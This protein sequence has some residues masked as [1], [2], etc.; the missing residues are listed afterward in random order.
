MRSFCF[1][2]WRKAEDEDLD[3]ELQAHLDIATE[4]RVNAGIPLR[5]ARRA[6]RH[7][8]GSITST[9]EDL[10]NMRTGAA[11]E[12]LWREARH[13]ARRLLRSPAFTLATVLTLALAIGANASIFAVVYRV[14]LKPLPYGAS[15]RLVALEFSV[16]ARNVAKVYYIPSRL[17]FQYLDRAHTLDGLALYVGTNEL[18]FTGQGSPERIHVSRTT[19]SLSSV[20][21]VA[22][23]VGRWFTDSES[24]PGASPAAV[25][26]HGFWVR[27]F[28]QDPNV[29]GRSITL[30]GVPTVV[31]G[32]MPTSFAFPDPRVDVW[33]PAPYVT[34]STATDGYAFAAVGRLREGATLAEARSELT[35]LAVELD[36]SYPNNGYKGLVSTAATLLDATVGNATVTL[37]I[38][39]TAVGLVLVVAC[40]N[41]ANLFLVRA[42]VRQ[43]EIAMRRA[44]G[45]GNR[46]VAQYFLA[47]STLLS[48]AGG[49][50]GVAV[51]WLALHMLVAF[52]PGVGPWWTSLPRIMKSASTPSCAHSPWRSV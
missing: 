24:E 5:D 17:Y 29:V 42:E 6:A 52:G 7:E 36:P 39:L 2:R 32:V 33:I 34:R 4:E 16:P 50:L 28:A 19:A 51:A 15:E 20:L 21:R 41:V 13:A 48:L 31:V 40:G 9:R 3:R 26:S 30:D 25:L 45:A 18:T 47:E 38:L 23:S 43:Q 37:W 11:I 46:E 12:R 49:T 10:R 8:F 14:V 44:L 27:R 35:R 22:P 1:W